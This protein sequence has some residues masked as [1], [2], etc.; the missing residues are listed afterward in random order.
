MVI[1]YTNLFAEAQTL[2][3][4]NLSFFFDEIDI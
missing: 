1:M 3:D 4:V 2:M